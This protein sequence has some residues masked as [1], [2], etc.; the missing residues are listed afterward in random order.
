MVTVTDLPLLLLCTFTLVPQ[1]NVLRAAVNSPSLS[2]P[3]QATL[4]PLDLPYWEASAREHTQTSRLPHLGCLHVYP[5]RARAY[6]QHRHVRRAALGNEP[7]RGRPGLFPVISRIDRCRRIWM[8]RAHPYFGRIAGNMKL[9]LVLRFFMMHTHLVGAQHD[10]HKLAGRIIHR[11]APR[12]STHER[13]SIPDVKA[14]LTRRAFR[15]GGDWA[16]S[17]GCAWDPV[18]LHAF[19]FAKLDGNFLSECPGIYGSYRKRL[20]FR[21]CAHVTIFPPSKIRG[22]YSK[23]RSRDRGYVP[24]SALRS[25]HCVDRGRELDHPHLMHCGGIRLDL[26]VCGKVRS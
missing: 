8:Q 12:A 22:L 19:D 21:S 20:K 7:L 4:E 2:L 5:T 9:I 3:P 17:D 11:P 10:K 14:R 26:P 24:L 6:A 13:V 23:F 15:L 25:R 1:G 16:G 18:P